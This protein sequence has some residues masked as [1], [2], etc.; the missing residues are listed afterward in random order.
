MA[1]STGSYIMNTL[2]A[3]CALPFIFG[4]DYSWYL[5]PVVR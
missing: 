2:A 5:Y 3:V 1:V 4:N